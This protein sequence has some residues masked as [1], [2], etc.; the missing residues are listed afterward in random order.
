MMSNAAAESRDGA[1]A[2]P[3]G[4]DAVVRRRA[5]I[6][7]TAFVVLMA[8]FTT[9]AEAVLVIWTPSWGFTLL[10]WSVGIAGLITL[11]AIDRSWRDVGFNSAARGYWIL[12]LA[13]PIV[14]GVATYVPVWIFGLGGFAGASRLWIAVLSTAVHFPPALFAAAGE[15]IGWRGVLVPNLARV[16]DARVVAFLP[17][18]I[19][20]VWHYPNMLIFG[21]SGTPLLVALI[22]FSAMVI[23]HGIFLAWLRL[24]SGSVWPGAVFHGA[25]NRS[26]AADVSHYHR[27]WRRIGACRRGHWMPFLAQAA[28]V[29]ACEG[30]RA[31]LPLVTSARRAQRSS[32]HRIR[33]R[34]VRR[35][36]DR[37]RVSRS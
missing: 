4:S 10:M 8:V 26:A 25:H 34:P 22:F 13:L 33:M 23:G 30:L 11:A 29:P 35:D 7:V 9:A 24:A 37:A 3:E 31:R 36:S 20:A 21:T 6:K 32:M 17:G 14:Y 19:W 1:D 2:G 18:A 5:W 15:E 28:C 16:A 12:A 27:V